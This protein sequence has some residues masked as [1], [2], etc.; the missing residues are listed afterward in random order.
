MASALQQAHLVVPSCSRTSATG[1]GAAAGPR[2]PVGA[3]QRS[4]RTVAP[5]RRSQITAAA[6]VDISTGRGLG[7]ALRPDFPI[8]DQQVNGHPLV[9]L[10]NAATSQKPTAVVAKLSEYYEGYNSN[11]HRGVHS[12]AA[13]A[14]T[15]YE[16]AR[17]KVASFINAA[18]DREIVYTRNASE[19]INLVANTWGSANIREGDEIVTTVMEHHSNIVP[20]QMLAQRTGAVLKF[21]KLNESQELDMEMMAELITPRTKLVS[22]V[23]V[24]NMLGC[25]NPVEEIVAMA[26][27]VGARV[28][29]DS[30]QSVPH[31]EVNVQALGADWI[32]ASGHKMC[33]PTGIGFLWGKSEVLE[34]MPPWMGGGEMIA[35]VFLEHSTYAEPPARFEAGTPA[36]AEAIAL[37]AAVDYLQAIGMDKVHDYEQELGE[38]LYTKL[39]EV[40]G[41]TIYGPTLSAK[42]GRAALCAFN[43]EG[44][45]ATDLS[46]LL[47]ASGVAVRSGHH[48]TQPVH[49]YLDIPASARASLYIYNTKAEVDTFIKELKE[50]V[51]FFSEMQL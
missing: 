25:V 46:T 40:P 27:K 3:R 1:G 10:D 45:H 2:L 36:I 13:R 32:V 15:E 42:G 4:V 44:L 26:A 35:D 30:C 5:R 31:M 17:A 47:D 6:A 9:Y 49:R 8:L 18:S 51:S 7:E 50:T 48:C 29:L 37:G 20:W 38:Y 22:V 14:T 21:C 43:V 16:A 33:A 41:V 19:A 34:S 28:L 11:V 24:S 12:L 23:H 39:S